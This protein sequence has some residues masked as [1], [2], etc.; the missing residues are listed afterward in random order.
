MIYDK[1]QTFRELKTKKS[2]YNLA[3]YYKLT[4]EQL[5]EIYEFL[6]ADPKNTI[7]AT[8]TEIKLFQPVNVLFKTI[9]TT[10]LIGTYGNVMFD[11]LNLDEYGEHILSHYIS[12]G[13]SGGS[14]YSSSAID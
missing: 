8:R 14:S 4:Q 7:N 6:M 1:A 9:A 5:N 2:V 10:A 12:S 3:N 13:R 11:G